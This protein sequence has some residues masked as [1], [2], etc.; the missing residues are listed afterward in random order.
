MQIARCDCSRARTEP[1]ESELRTND[2]DAFNSKEVDFAGEVTDDCVEKRE[3]EQLLHKFN[4]DI[5]SDHRTA[6]S[7]DSTW[8]S[9]MVKLFFLLLHKLHPGR[10]RG[11]TE[12]R[13]ANIC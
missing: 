8:S 1:P 5:R 12:F 10:T 3:G 7:A 4:R 13:V 2:G 11:A 6:G 9:Q